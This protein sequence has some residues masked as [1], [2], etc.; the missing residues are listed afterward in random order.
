MKDFNEYRHYLTRLKLEAEQILGQQEVGKA[1]CS[2]A[3]DGG[4]Q[5]WGVP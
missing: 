4:A 5:G 2:G 1:G 3:Q